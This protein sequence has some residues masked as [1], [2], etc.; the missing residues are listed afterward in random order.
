MKPSRVAIIG[1]TELRDGEWTGAAAIAIETAA[2]WNAEVGLRSVAATAGAERLLRARLAS[3]GVSAWLTARDAP[4]APPSPVMLADVR[5]GDPLQ[6]PQLFDHDVII[7]ASR[8]ARL[9]RFLA[10]LPVHTRPDVRIMA[11]LHFD[12]GPVVGERL[13][14][15]LRFDTL[16]GSEDDFRQ[17]DISADTEMAANALASLRE[18]MHGSNLR[19][20]ISWSDRGSFS[21][22][23][24]HRPILTVGP[25]TTAR[26]S[27]T[28]WPAF[29]GA[30]A[31]GIA[32]R[33]PWPEIGR[34]AAEAYR[35]GSY[36]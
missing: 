16:I 28:S 33:D 15:L 3:A 36:T 25:G 8:D 34:H 32:R 35:R 12:H 10:D 14:D 9:R 11:L 7:L 2:R 17:L 6:I 13:E 21:L 1:D 18:H 31:A 23:E 19:A 4:D 22:A 30:V 29:V 5:M 26:M 20:A 27:S 24:P